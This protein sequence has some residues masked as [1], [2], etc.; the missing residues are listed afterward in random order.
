VTKGTAPAPLVITNVRFMAASQDEVKTG[1][2]GY[3]SATLNDS[4]ALD[5][6]TLRRTTDGRLALSFPARRDNAGRQRFFLRPLGDEAR[7][8]IEGQIFRSLGFSPSGP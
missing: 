5:G 8:E 1:L 4:L 2:L 7:R 6:L 3:V